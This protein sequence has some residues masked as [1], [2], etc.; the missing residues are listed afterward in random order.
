MTETIE[1]RTLREL[2]AI[3]LRGRRCYSIA[4]EVHLDNFELHTHHKWND[5]LPRSYNTYRHYADVVGVSKTYR[6]REV[7][8][9]E[10]LA[11]VVYEPRITAI[12]VKVS[13]SDFN[14]G[15][16]DLGAHYIYVLTPPNLLDPAAIPEKVG[17]LE[18]DLSGY[19]ILSWNSIG[20]PTVREMMVEKTGETGP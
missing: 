15:F 13:K 16:V 14:H 5:P 9:G 18:L 19:S 4:F 20:G 11:H 3:W 7:P 1:H 2:A 12:E 8:P 10:T 17:L 6:G